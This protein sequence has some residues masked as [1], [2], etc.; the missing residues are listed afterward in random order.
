MNLHLRL[1]IS[2]NSGPTPSLINCLSRSHAS[3]VLVPLNRFFVAGSFELIKCLAYTDLQSS[4]H[5]NAQ[6][7][8][9][10]PNLRVELSQHHR[11]SVHRI[12]YAQTISHP[13]LLDTQNPYISRSMHRPSFEDGASIRENP[14]RPQFPGVDTGGKS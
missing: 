3:R 11:A 9:H 2:S 5:R 10:D 6:G 4:R 12:G 1:N 13:M 8:L 14:Q 7:D